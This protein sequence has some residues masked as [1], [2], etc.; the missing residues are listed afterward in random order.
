[1]APL[2]AENA[3]DD[4]VAELFSCGICDDVMLDPTTLGCCG[5]S[6]CRRCL[7]QWTR[8]SVHSAGIPRCPGGCAQKLPFRLPARSHALRTAIEQLLPKRLER[9]KKDD[10]EQESCE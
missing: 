5:R 2:L 6:F 7:R 8:T 1:M 9:R 3:E 4:A 10:E